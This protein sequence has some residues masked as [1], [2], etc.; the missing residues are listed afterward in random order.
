MPGPLGPGGIA[1]T[2]SC[3][4]I[5]LIAPRVRHR[6]PHAAKVILV[7]FHRLLDPS[8]ADLRMRS[9]PSADSCCLASVTALRRAVLLELDLPPDVDAS[10]SARLLTWQLERW[11]WRTCLSLG[12]SHHRQ[13]LGCLLRGL[14]LPR[15]PDDLVPVVGLPSL[16]LRH[17]FHGAGLHDTAVR[18]DANLVGPLNAANEPSRRPLGLQLVH[19]PLWPGHN[20]VDAL[21]EG[22]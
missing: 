2:I 20:E 10:R 16:L 17:A 9:G 6:D 19:V 11:W 13:R 3:P 22:Y 7:V 12:D 15:R 1:S 5:F 18:H 4:S 21:G 8:S 14:R